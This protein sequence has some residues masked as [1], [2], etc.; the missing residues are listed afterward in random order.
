[1][2]GSAYVNGTTMGTEPRGH[3]E[4]IGDVAEILLDCFENN[5]T[6]Q[7][8]KIV[9]VPAASYAD[10]NLWE[11][12]RDT[13]FKRLPLM[14]ALTCEMPNPG[15]Y[16]AMEVVGLPVLIARDKAGTVRAFFNVCA[17]RWA[18]VAAEGLGH[19]LNFRFIC[20]FH[21]WTY[22]TDGRLIGIAEQRKFGDLDK[23]S[24]GLR[25][26][27][28]E[29]RHGMIFVCLTPGT[30]LDLDAHYGAFL[31]EFA[32]FRLKDWYFLGTHVLDGPNWKLIWTNFFESYHFAT[33]HPLTVLPRYLS[34]VNHYEGF[35]PNMR[36]GFAFRTIA[37]LRELPR[38]Q[39]E[40]QEG[41]DFQFMRFFF[42]NVNAA[43]YPSQISLFVLLLP[44][45]TP[46]RTR[47]VSLYLREKPPQDASERAAIEHE[48]KRISEVGDQT[49]RDEDFATAFA[50]Q[51]ALGSGAHPGFLY[52][53]N[54]RGP[55][56]FHEWVN[57]YLKADPSLPRPVL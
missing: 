7:T 36:I 23:S 15:D 11:A 33:Q 4:R 22:G 5:R 31:Q 39:W 42:P 46:D 50:T 37:R 9:T 8:D 2:T 45:P 52:G 18:P 14:L 1:M 44:G 12:E 51:K 34:N 27:P 21:G 19:C 38:A 26:L 10:S 47:V 17:H 57:W 32:D 6:F 30:P 28:C 41:H 3:R 55:Q 13:I 56:Y 49:L 43:F 35:G 24:H 53:R 25:A 20:P 48:L 16:K 40:R 54:E 29:E